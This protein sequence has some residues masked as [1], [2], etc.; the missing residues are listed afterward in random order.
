VAVWKSVQGEGS[1]AAAGLKR[2]A[3]AE[4]KEESLPSSWPGWQG[5]TGARTA[6][7]TRF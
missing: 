4:E 1:G 6:T 5:H 7:H 3:A 2:S